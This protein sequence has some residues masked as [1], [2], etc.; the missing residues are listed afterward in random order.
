MMFTKWLLDNF[1][2]EIAN[3]ADQGFS[4]T[5]GYYIRT[6]GSLFVHR[7]KLWLK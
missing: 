7:Q 5:F 6:A 4:K 1:L 2:V 3:K